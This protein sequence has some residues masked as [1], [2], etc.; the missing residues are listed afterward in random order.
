MVISFM[1]GMVVCSLL[2]F[3]VRMVL[4]VQSVTDETGTASEN[5]T[6]GLSKLLPDIEKIYRESLQM[7]FIKAE[8]KIYDKDI[9]EYYRALMDKTG[10]APR[11]G[12]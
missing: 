1:V 12:Q 9:A 8:S 4:P 7:P 11:Q 10:L 3:G 2:L 6:N 5:T